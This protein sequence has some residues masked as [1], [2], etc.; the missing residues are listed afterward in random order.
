MRE[1]LVLAPF[2]H[3]LQK[4]SVQEIGTKQDLKHLALCLIDQLIKNQFP[5]YCRFLFYFLL[6]VYMTDLLSSLVK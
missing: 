3:T 5:N 4:P 6:I 2:L 1:T